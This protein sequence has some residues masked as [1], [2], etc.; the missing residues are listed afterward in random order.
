MLTAI[1]RAVSPS[2]DDC[3]LTFHLRQQI[4]VARAASQHHAYEECLR[5]LGVRVIS[6]PAEPALPDSVF[7]EDAAIIVDELAIMTFMGAVS[8]RGETESL[9]R[10]LSEYRPI[11]YMQS[12]AT[13]DGGDVMRIGRAL[14]VGAS[15]RT[16]AEG[17][18]QLRGLLAPF[19]Y[20]VRA[21]EVTGCLHLK[22]ACTYIGRNSILIN[23]AWIDAAQLESFE[24][25]DVP[26]E[27][28]NAANA[29]LVGDVVVMPDSFPQTRAM[30]EGRGFN[31]RA[32]DVSELQKA[33]GGVTCK[34][35]IFNA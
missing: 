24:L 4:D 3:E 15:S 18:S 9:A 23:R 34:S 13:L 7:V 12:P 22:S 21:V 16:N 5:E 35:L 17:A 25:V 19:D 20:Q 30:L 8:R 6:L 32:V 10:A 27:E 26:T 28:P 2:I 33:E 1:T 31:V 29:L 11:K 14:Y